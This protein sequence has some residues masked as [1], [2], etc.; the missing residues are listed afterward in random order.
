MVAD[1]KEQLRTVLRA[2]ERQQETWLQSQRTLLKEIANERELIL[3]AHNLSII[4]N[5][6]VELLSSR[7]LADARN[8]FVRKK[9]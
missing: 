6:P 3:I 9:S 5:D 8:Y 1:L 2:V 4:A 7:S